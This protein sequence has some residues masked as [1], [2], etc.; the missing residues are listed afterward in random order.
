MLR[1][2]VAN[3]GSYCVPQRSRS[4]LMVEDNQLITR[5]HTIMLQDLDCVVETAS[6]AAEALAKANHP[7]DL[8]LLDVGLPDMKG[9]ELAAQLRL[10]PSHEYTPMVFVTTFSQ[11][12]LQEV[13]TYLNIHRVITK[14]V[15]KKIFRSVLLETFH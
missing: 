2:A 12:T 4:I 9:T 7:Y 3:A 1:Q 8:I 5:I 14:P 13:C 10:H 15:D 11:E 6:T